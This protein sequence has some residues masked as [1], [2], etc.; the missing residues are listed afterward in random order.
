MK[1]PHLICSHMNSSSSVYTVG[2]QT[3]EYD[4]FLVCFTESVHHMHTVCECHALIER[5]FS[6][7]G[8]QVTSCFIMLFRAFVFS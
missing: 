7:V 4:V 2:D 1:K 8:N 3:D 6:K 5:A